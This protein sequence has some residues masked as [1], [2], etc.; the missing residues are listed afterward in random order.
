MLLQVVMA[1]SD[2]ATRPSFNADQPDSQSQLLQSDSTLTVG[3]STTL[4]LGS[5]ALVIVGKQCLKSMLAVMVVH[6]VF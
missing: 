3:Q 4:V 2:G 6:C 5:D 1:S